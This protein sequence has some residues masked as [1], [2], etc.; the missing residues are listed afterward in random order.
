M[1]GG[2]YDYL[3]GK[4]DD[5]ADSIVHRRPSNLRRMFADHLRL[6]SHAMHEIEWNDS[7]DGADDEDMAI[8]TVLGAGWEKCEMGM[9]IEAAE[10]A[11]HELNEAVAKAKEA[12]DA[13]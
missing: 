9:L 1:S 10:H 8:K 13:L 2:S 4:V 3:Y 11:C 6:V 5:M 12:R 7:G